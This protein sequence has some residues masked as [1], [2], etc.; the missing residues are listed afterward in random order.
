MRPPAAA[1][2][3]AP[4]HGAAAGGAGGDPGGWGKGAAGTPGFERLWA[5]RRAGFDPRT[6]SVKQS[7]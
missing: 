6:P 7:H 5:G 4:G 1:E 3:G 2:R